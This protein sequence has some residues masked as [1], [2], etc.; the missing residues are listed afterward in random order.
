MTHADFL[1]ELGT[2][3]LPP[4]ALKTLQDAFAE[5]LLNRLKEAGL[6]VGDSERFGA[7]RRLALT[8]RD[9]ELKQPDEAFERRGPAVKAAFDA[10]GQPTKAAEGFARSNG[11]SVDQLERMSTDK[12]EW[13]VY[14]GVEPGRATKDLLP[15]LVQATLDHLPIPKRMRWGASRDEFVRP[16]HWL[17]MLL[18]DDVVPA[19]V[20]GIEADRYSRG[21]RFHAPEP[22]RIERPTDYADQ[23]KKQGWVLASFEERRTTIV[24]QTKAKAEAEGV[25]AVIDD[26]LLDEVT[27][28]NEWPVALVGRFDERFL[29]VPAEALVSSMQEHQ[30]YF[31]TMDRDGRLASR[32]VFIANLESKDPAQVISGNEKVIRPRLAD[33]AFF[34]DTDRK[35]PLVDR[36]EKLKAVTF[37]QQL[38]TLHDKAGRLKANAG[39]I[40]R[41]LGDDV[42]IA[43]RAA[44]LAKADLVTD[45]VFEFDDM[46]GIAGYYYAL[47]D[48][49]PEPVAQAILEQY[50]PVG[51]GAELP[52]SR[53]GMAVALADR[54]DNLS[55]LFGI[56][57]PPTGTKDPFALR[58]AALGVLHILVERE[59]DL[60]LRELVAFAA[61][62]HPAL[63]KRD[64]VVD[65]VVDYALDRFSAW[66]Q[67]AGF[68]PDVFQ[69][70]RALN[71]S[72]PLD[73]DRR[74]KAVAGFSALDQA[75]ALA[76]ANKRVANLL[77]KAADSLD[78]ELAEGYAKGGA[79]W[80]AHQANPSL[81]VESAETTLWDAIEAAE[82]A[83]G[84]L[85]ETVDYQGALQRLATLREDVDAYFD[86]VMV[87][88]DDPAVRA[89]RLAVLARLRLLFL[90]VADIS[91]L[92]H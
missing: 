35:T 6:S 40:A 76:A 62:Q 45:M 85:L 86:Q 91:V 15:E 8:V 79:A 25:D 87:M 16:V 58:R 51:A 47:H 90:Q 33:A 28:L 67:D 5:G 68:R 71:P 89:N 2:E 92:Q 80:L 72:R 53:A 48:G 52:T 78:G 50:K 22:I 41:R 77:N 69:A 61:D 14:R 9:L 54:L 24:E 83:V 38:G 32:F 30:K 10:D 88:A 42:E 11:V 75:N 29:E 39:E 73:I 60:D 4:K 84:P 31:P 12:G 46:Q 36:V 55:G 34:W 21:H 70:V 43:E 82:H 23:L 26:D 66:Y 20:Y 19:T 81:F 1:I 13:L 49:E 57:Q 3:E 64:T 18:G 17:L 7:P 56:G 63:P 44:W 65:Q 27:A 59:L 74:V 37:Q